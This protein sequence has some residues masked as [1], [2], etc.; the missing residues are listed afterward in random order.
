MNEGKGNTVLLTIIGIA[1]LLIAVIGATFAYFTAI[2]SG[3][4]TNT[5]FTINS[6]TIGTVFVGGDAIVAQNVHPSAD[7]LVVKIF[8]IKGNAEGSAMVFYELGLAVSTNTFSA[9][10]LK[11][12]LTVDPSSSSNGTRAPEVTTQTN[13]PTDIGT[14]SLGA[15]T[16]VGPTGGE[17]AHKYILTIFFPETGVNQ[18][19]DQGKTFY[20]HV[21][22]DAQSGGE[23]T[24]TTTQP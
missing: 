15:G 18:N 10:A 5:T 3:K 4:E 14:A 24:T 6:G 23:Q 16:F 9:G 21:T 1:T 11:Y 7:P 13:I 8:T 22:I 2:L 12:T 19:D 17:V 20:G